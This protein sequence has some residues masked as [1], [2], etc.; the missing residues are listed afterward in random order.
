MKE[1]IKY[2]LNKIKLIGGLANNHDVFVVIMIILVSLASFG[3]GRL[4]KSEENKQPLQII[5][6][7]NEALIGDFPEFNG[8]EQIQ[9]GKYVASKSG[10]KYHLPWCSGA[11]RIKESNKIWFDSKNEAEK[12]GYQPAGNCKGI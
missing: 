6:S 1:S 9:I 3:L 2:L 10:K 12:A 4:S 5:P 11:Q 8:L 7:Q